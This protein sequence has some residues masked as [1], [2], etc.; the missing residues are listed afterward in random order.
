M[1]IYAPVV[2]WL[3]IRMF[4]VLSVIKKW[5]TPQVDFVLAYTR[6]HIENEHYNKLTNGIETKKGKGKT[7]VLK[8]IR[9]LHGQKQSE[10]VWNRYLTEII[11]TIGLKQSTIGECIL[12]W[13]HAIFTWYIDYVILISP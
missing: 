4:L 6:V 12:Y 5:H 9:K 8:L 10:W 2:T 13:G 7:H 1:E 11:V 3:S